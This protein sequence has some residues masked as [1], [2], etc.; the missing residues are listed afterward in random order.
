MISVRLL[1]GSCSIPDILSR[2]KVALGDHA[3]LKGLASLQLLPSVDS[4]N[5]DADEPLVRILGPEVGGG[6]GLCDPRVPHDG[7]FEVV[8]GD[9][10]EGL[11]VLQHG[12]GVLLD[13]LV[14]AVGLA[15]DGDGGVGL[16]VFGGIEDL[17]SVGSG[18]KAVDLELGD[19]LKMILARLCVNVNDHH[20]SH[21]T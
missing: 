4:A 20:H 9:V 11:A 7:V 16:G 1:S 2:S 5:L 19:V 14:D 6:L 12:G 21:H 15:G 10:E 17:V 13:G 18:A 3:A 8:A